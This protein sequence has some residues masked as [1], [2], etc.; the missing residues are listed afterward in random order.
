MPIRPENRKLYPSNW[1][2]IR[3]SI[4]TRANNCCEFCGVVNHSIRRNEAGKDIRIVLTV[5]HLDHHPQNCSPDNLKALCQRCHSR[6]DA[7]HRAETRR[8]S[9]CDSKVE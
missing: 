4:L 1:K 2:D 9:K 3:E 5:A 7:R 6:Y 8:K